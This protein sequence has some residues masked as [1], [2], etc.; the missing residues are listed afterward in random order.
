MRCNDS[1]HPLASFRFIRTFFGR[2]PKAR[3]A[4]MREAKSDDDVRGVFVASWVG[5]HGEMVLLGRKS[6]RRL[7]RPPVEIPIG[8]SH[9][10]A[11]DE[12]WRLLDDEDPDR[13][14]FMRAM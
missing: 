1:L 3:G 2:T 4:T 9:H 6:D 5:L 13:R 12:L 11:A 8:A 7:V 10:A 14:S